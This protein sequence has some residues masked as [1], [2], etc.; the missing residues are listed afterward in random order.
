M[1]RWSGGK[2]FISNDCAPLYIWGDDC[3][4]NE[5]NEKLIAIVLGH[6]LDPRTFSIEVCWPIFV[7]REV[8]FLSFFFKK[9]YLSY[10]F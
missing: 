7:L 1:G 2:P 9:N 4:F 8:P 5:S 6:A 3:V 10:A